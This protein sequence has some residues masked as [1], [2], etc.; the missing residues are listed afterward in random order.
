MTRLCSAL[1]LLGLSATV[2]T[3]QQ[4]A[5]RPAPQL[6]NTLLSFV[7]DENFGKELKLTP[8]Q[9][10]KFVEYRKKQWD[11]SYTTA[12]AE[13]TKG[14]A[15]RAAATAALFKEVLTA[16][17]HK[18]AV[19][20]AAQNVWGSLRGFTGR[21]GPAAVA[22]PLDL[23]KAPVT[24]LRQY[25]DIADA[26]KLTDEQ[27]KL[28]TPRSTGP[29]G[30]GAEF[31]FLTP[32]QS[33]AAKELLGEP[34]KTA[35][36]SAFDTRARSAFRGGRNSNVPEPLGLL[37]AKDV[38]AEIGMTDE[39]VKAF[40]PLL[41]KWNAN[42]LASTR[43]IS[44][45]A[46]QKATKELEA[47]TDKALAAT[48]KPEQLARLRQ[49]DQQTNAGVGGLGGRGVFGGEPTTVP[50]SSQLRSLVTRKAIAFTPEQ[51]KALAA[52][53]KA[54]GDA[55]A[56]AV[57]ADGSV[58]DAIKAI[59]AAHDGRE[60]AYAAALTA[61]QKTKL[62]ELLGKPF[63]GSTFPD[64]LSGGP[65]AGPASDAFKAMRTASFGQRP[66]IELT[67]L[68]SNKSIQDELALKPE[69]VKKATE[70]YQDYM[71][72]YGPGG[73]N[74]PVRGGTGA[75]EELAK[76]RAEVSAFVEKAV[77]EFLTADQ[78]KRFRQLMLQRAEA[79]NNSTRRNATTVPGAISYAGVAEAVKLTAEQK[80]KLID[81]EK[82]DEVLTADQKAA[83]KGMLGK[84]FEG[85]WTT[86]PT[87]GPGGGFRRLDAMPTTAAVLLNVSWDVFKLTP[88]QV[89]KLVPV[90]NEYQLE[91]ARVMV[92]IEGDGE[93]NGFRVQPVDPAK[94]AAADEK[95]TKALADTLTPE[96]AKRVEQVRYQ[97]LASNG[98]TYLTNPAVA[99][100]LDLKD[101]QR[102]KIEAVY[103]DMQRLQSAARGPLT[104]FTPLGT[105]QGWG[106]KLTEKRTAQANAVL[107]DEQKATWKAL[108]GD[109]VPNL[110]VLQFGGFAGPGGPGGFGGGGF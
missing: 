101:E 4:P 3:A 81:G 49:I 72:K 92:P 88:E 10:K 28:L 89:T 26:L 17:Q 63:T 52:A 1:L 2:A 58:D 38:R 11:E 25:A 104:Q 94:L 13:Y 93:R 73:T 77:G 45:E 95:L 42:T 15:E 8:D 29:A 40:A 9:V 56:A 21:G 30:V 32:E 109:P 24:A 82:S 102:A 19:Q 66:P 70:K 35:W 106:P 31:V 7:E 36:N 47:E 83:I 85:D 60:K 22:P 108:T 61:E 34:V 65:G 50:L 80:T 46:L 43:D 71:T 75:L 51:D 76:Q 12:P 44:P 90:V 87:T 67:L 33:K 68:G 74:R 23:T 59:T 69:Q 16:E 20:L 64:R 14:A 37:E 5:A 54:H 53:D 100:A 79:E 55:L 27:K 39:Q 86:R 91:T 103:T 84:K 98:P 6:V 96:Q 62:D 97:L 105:Q 41:E 107:T 48:L 18:R 78:V 57:V 99:K 110:P